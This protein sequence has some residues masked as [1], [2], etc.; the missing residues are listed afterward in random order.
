MRMWRAVLT[1]LGA[2]GGT[3]LFPVAYAAMP[4]IDI[5]TEGGTL[6][7][8]DV[9]RAV[10]IFLKHCPFLS[11]YREDLAMFKVLVKPEYIHER[12]QRGWKTEIYITIKISDRPNAVPAR[13]RGI[14]QTAGQYLYFN[15]GGGET[16]G[17]TGTK[18]MSQFICG[19]PP[20]RRGID[21][22]RPIPELSFLEY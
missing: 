5:E 7:R 9:E 12:L 3:L 20:N 8:S 18:R 11:Q 22:F 6:T 10:N 2:I 21:S 4:Q 17:V 19:L 1:A 16:P 15:I 14:G 13:I